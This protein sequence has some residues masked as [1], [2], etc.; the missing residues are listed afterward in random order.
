MTNP[1][2]QDTPPDAASHILTLAETV[3]GERD[4]ALS[5]LTAPKR[6][7]GNEAP[8]DLLDTE[9]GARAVEE[10]LYSIDEGYF[11]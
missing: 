6:S 8:M 11:V 1:T 7:L 9:T 3:M 2:L 10:L 5:W 4:H